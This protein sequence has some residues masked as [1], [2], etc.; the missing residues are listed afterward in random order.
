MIDLTDGITNGFANGQF[1]L[2]SPPKVFKNLVITGARV[3]ES[4]ALGY[5]GD[6]RAWDLHT[7]KMVWQFHHVA[8]PGTLG[9]DTWEGD[10]WRNRSGANTWG[11]LSVDPALGLV[12]LPIGSPSYDFYGGDRKGANLF[13]DSIVALDAM[14]GAYRWHFQAVHHDTWDFDFAAAPVLDR[15]RAQRTAHSGAGRIVETRFRLHPRSPDGHADLRHGRAPRAA[16]RRAGGDRAGRP[17]RFRSSRRRRRDRAS[18]RAN[19]RG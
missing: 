3:G 18:N 2:S 10:S 6:T 7:G 13:S 19:W 16:K 15:C 14:T 11:F 17:S 4:P 8:R 1:S 12:Y 5:A 9:G